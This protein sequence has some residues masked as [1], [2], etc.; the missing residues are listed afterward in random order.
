MI[1]FQRSTDYAAVRELLTEPRCWR[2]MTGTADSGLAKRFEV[3]PC[4][5]IEYVIANE[6]GSLL[7]SFQLIDGAATA[8]GAAEFHL[9]FAPAA[10]GRAAAI[11]RDFLQWVWSETTYTRL[12]G[13]VPAYNRLTLRLA[14]ETGWAETAFL[15]NVIVKHGTTHD[16]VFVEIRKPCP[17][18]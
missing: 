5:G 11:L 18:S 1:E 9:C 13:P 4:A 3:G 12:I 16:V 14:R 6:K 10:W 7:A 15:K 8:P 17:P 2:R